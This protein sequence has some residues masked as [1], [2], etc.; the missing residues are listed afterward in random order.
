[1]KKCWVNNEQLCEFEKVGEDKT[2]RVDV[3]I[4]CGRK[5]RF[6]KDKE[7]NV[8]DRKFMKEHRRDFLQRVG[9]DADLFKKV[10][11]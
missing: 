7:G 4:H 9:N 5:V 11:G 1:M 6:N 8:D 3:C 10:Y 2:V